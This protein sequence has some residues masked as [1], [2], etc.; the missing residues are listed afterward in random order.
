MRSSHQKININFFV[1]RRTS[2][3]F[4]RLGLSIDFLGL[5]CKLWSKN[6]SYRNSREKVKT[7]RVVNDCSER[8]VKLTSNYANILTKDEDPK[9]YLLQCID[10]FKK[11]FQNLNKTSIVKRF[12]ASD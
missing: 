7:L 9:L 11:D 4:E 2:N 1:D 6:S 12:K 3:F 10:E 5:D 8:A